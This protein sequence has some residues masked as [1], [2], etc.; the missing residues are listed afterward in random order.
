VTSAAL[1]RDVRIRMFYPMSFAP[2]RFSATRMYD[3]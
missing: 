2:S 3:A 1:N